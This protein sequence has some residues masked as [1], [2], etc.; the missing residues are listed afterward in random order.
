MLVAKECEDSAEKDIIVQNPTQWMIPMFF[1]FPTLLT[2][3]IIE[4]MYLWCASAV[5][6]SSR[7]FMMVFRVLLSLSWCAGKIIL[8]V[9]WCFNSSAL[10]WSLI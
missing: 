8:D 2:L 9:M 3:W 5:G 1:I 7:I 6:M 4:L 10:G